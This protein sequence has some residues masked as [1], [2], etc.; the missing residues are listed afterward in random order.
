MC[1][2][3]SETINITKGIALGDTSMTLVNVALLSTC[4]VIAPSGANA[5]T[6]I[7]IPRACIDVSKLSIICPLSALSISKMNLKNASRFK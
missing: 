3:V 7:Q 4:A 5:I 6:K 1:P 2:V